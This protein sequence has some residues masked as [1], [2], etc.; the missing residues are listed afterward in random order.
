MQCR[1]TLDIPSRLS[2]RCV[3]VVVVVVGAVVTVVVV[4]AVVVVTVRASNVYYF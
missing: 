2:S 3:A 1:R 4:I